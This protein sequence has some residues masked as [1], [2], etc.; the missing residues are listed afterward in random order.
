M[1]KQA[2][3]TTFACALLGAGVGALTGNSDERG[4]TTLAGAVSGA[5]LGAKIKFLGQLYRSMR[6]RFALN[7]HKHALNS[8]MRKIIKAYGKLGIPVY[9]QIGGSSIGNAMYM[10]GKPGWAGRKGG[11]VFMDVLTKKVVTDPAEKAI[12]LGSN[13]DK[14]PVL[15]HE[16]GHAQDYKEMSG[17][18]RNLRRGAN[19]AAIGGFAG[20][21]GI[22]IASLLGKMDKDVAENAL[23]G[24]SSVAWGG[25]MLRHYLSRRDERRAS[26]RAIQVLQKVQKPKQLESSKRLLERAYATYDP[27]RFDMPDFGSG[28]YYPQEKAAKLA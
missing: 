17:L 1:D 7:G 15:A 12:Y 14:L 2:L 8:D 9:Q 28:E 4:K 16:L 23:L 20:S 6:F 27:I 11:P 5:A 24:T 22:I 19:I 3:D 21:I 26:D 10:E 18:S 13:F 25:S